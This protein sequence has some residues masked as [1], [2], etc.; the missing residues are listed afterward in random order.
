M[1][2][3]GN[4]EMALYEIRSSELMKNKK[5]CGAVVYSES[6]FVFVELCSYIRVQYNFSISALLSFTFYFQ[7]PG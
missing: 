6:G 4:T 7:A 5:A 2:L 1:L 3:L